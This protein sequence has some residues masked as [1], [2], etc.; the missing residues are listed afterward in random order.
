MHKVRV[1]RSPYGYELPLI[2]KRI[3]MFLKIGRPKYPLNFYKWR[4]FY[5]IINDRRV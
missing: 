2:P 3:G 5:S 4:N 1:F